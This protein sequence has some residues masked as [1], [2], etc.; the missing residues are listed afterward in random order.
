MRLSITTN[1]ARAPAGL[2]SAA[3]PFFCKLT[4]IC[5]VRSMAHGC[6][7]VFEGLDG[8]GQST[9]VALLANRLQKDG[10]KV[11]VTKEPTNN[12]IGG[13]IRGALTGEWKTSN[14]ILQ[15][16]YAADRGHHLEREI[17][18]ALEKG[19]VVISDRYYFS[20]IAFGSFN[21]DVRWLT[22]INQFYRDPDYAFYIRVNP[23]TALKRIHKSRFEFELFEKEKEL[24]HIAKAYDKLTKKYPVLRPINGE[25]AIEDIHEAIYAECRDTILKYCPLP[26]Q[27]G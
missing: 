8:S 9:Q 11:H 23:Q 24:T 3:R 1:H 15:L 4:H 14:H 6:F 25:Q 18:P 21:V 13:L 27:K 12:L 7:I 22:T 26:K 2:L 17:L 20:S 19:Y 16:L 5:Y 10:L